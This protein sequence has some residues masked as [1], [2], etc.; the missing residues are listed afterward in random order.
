[1]DSTLYSKVDVVEPVRSDF[2]NCNSAAIAE[3]FLYHTFLPLHSSALPRMRATQFIQP[4]YAATDLI[5]RPRKN[6]PPKDKLSTVITKPIRHAVRKK[7]RCGE[8]YA[9][10]GPM[11]QSCVNAVI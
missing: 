11:K 6:Y 1:M 2:D 9:V 4:I 5:V 8:S 3:A 10:S 7:L